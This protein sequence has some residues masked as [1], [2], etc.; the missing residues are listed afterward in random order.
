MATLGQIA[1]WDR[2]TIRRYVF[3]YKDFDALPVSSIERVLQREGFRIGHGPRMTYKL[4]PRAKTVT[5]EQT[6]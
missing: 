6:I 3:S 4:D 2:P 5:Y 1:G